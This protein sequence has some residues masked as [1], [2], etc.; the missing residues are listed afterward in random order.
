[1]ATN[2]INRAFAASRAAHKKLA[3]V[4]VVI[5]RG[6]SSSGVVTAT[7]GFAGDSI[8][9]PSD[10]NQILMRHLT[11]L[12]DVADYDVGSGPTTPAR[13][14]TI[15]VTIGGE[16]TTFEVLEDNADSVS[17]YQGPDRTFWRVHTKELS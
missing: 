8:E 17:T 1:M 5:T 4:S 2:P 9:D 7:L 10:L 16:V 6:L 3:G 13:H 14:D 15:R 12:I 11:F